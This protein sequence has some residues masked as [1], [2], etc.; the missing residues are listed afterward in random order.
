MTVGN[1]FNSSAA[2]ELRGVTLTA[3]SVPHDSGIFFTVLHPAG[4]GAP[5]P[6]KERLVQFVADACLGKPLIDYL[7][8]TLEQSRLQDFEIAPQESAWEDGR[9]VLVC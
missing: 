4:P 5:Y 2:D 1:C 9:G 7:G 8:V 3:C 6:G